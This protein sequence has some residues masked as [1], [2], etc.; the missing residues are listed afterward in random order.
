MLKISIM[1][2]FALSYVSCSSKPDVKKQ[3]YATL[4]AEKDFEANKDLMTVD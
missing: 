3:E 1:L 2:I 4:S